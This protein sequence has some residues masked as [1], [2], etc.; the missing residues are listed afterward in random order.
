[1]E[2]TEVA[3]LIMRRIAAACR[4]QLE[5]EEGFRKECHSEKDKETYS[6]RILVASQLTGKI[7]HLIEI[8]A[9]LM[10]LFIDTSIKT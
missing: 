6:Q 8:Y 3:T 1:M 7:V 5:Q 2:D 4:D 9:E 10:E